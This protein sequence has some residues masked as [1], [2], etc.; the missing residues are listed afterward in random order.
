MVIS[1]RIGALEIAE[2]ISDRTGSYVDMNLMQFLAVDGDRIQCWYMNSDGE[3]LTFEIELTRSND[4]WS[5]ALTER[6]P[7]MEQEIEVP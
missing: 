7:G 2:A 3:G 5:L 4:G 6:P 1:T